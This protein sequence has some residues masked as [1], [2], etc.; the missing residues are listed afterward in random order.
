MTLDN[1]VFHVPMT[2]YIIV[3]I[4]NVYGILTDKEVIGCQCYQILHLSILINYMFI[5]LLQS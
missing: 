4:M 3:V 1:I 5:R 2:A